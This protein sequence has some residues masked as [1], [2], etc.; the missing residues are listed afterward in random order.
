MPTPPIHIPPTNGSPPIAVP[1][2]Y[3]PPESGQP[4]GIWPS[5]GQPS[6]PIVIPPVPPASALPP[7]TQAV[8]AVVTQSGKVTLVAIDSNGKIT[9]LPTPGHGLPPT[10][11][12]K[13]A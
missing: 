9:P 12:P 11:Q 13:P 7:D 2:I 1:P 8:V 6:H 4:P 10:A 5:P 3:L